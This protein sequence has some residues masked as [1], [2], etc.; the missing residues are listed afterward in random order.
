MLAIMADIWCCRD[1]SIFVHVY[2][3]LFSE[4]SAAG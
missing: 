1:Q 4:V 3:V 2:N